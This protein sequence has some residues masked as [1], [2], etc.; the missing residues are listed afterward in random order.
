LH[1]GVI[2][3]IVDEYPGL[4]SPDFNPAVGRQV[5]KMCYAVWICAARIEAAG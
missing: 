1:R 3:L 5:V 2:L 4:I